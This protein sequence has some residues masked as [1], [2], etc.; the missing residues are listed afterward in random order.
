[1][2]TSSFRKKW[3]LG[4]YTKEGT[5]TPQSKI[6][7]FVITKKAGERNLHEKRRGKTSLE[8]RGGQP[9]TSEDVARV[10]TGE[11]GRKGISVKGK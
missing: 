9:T 4:W 10:L 3:L 7:P 11:R 5:A 2:K 6:Q 8:K 1:M